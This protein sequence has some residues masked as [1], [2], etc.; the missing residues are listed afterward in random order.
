MTHLHAVDDSNYRT[1]ESRPT[2]ATK[3]CDNSQHNIVVWPGTIVRKCCQVSSIRRSSNNCLWEILSSEYINDY[4]SDS[5]NSKQ[6]LC[7]A[8]LPN[9]I[10][11]S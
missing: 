9:I 11:S 2:H 5:C 7:H 3:E 8:L 6:I 10:R 4:C 1:E